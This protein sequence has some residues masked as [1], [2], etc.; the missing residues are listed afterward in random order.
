VHTDELDTIDAIEA[1][2]GSTLSSLVIVSIMAGLMVGSVPEQILQMMAR[3]SKNF[4][5][6]RE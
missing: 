6:V 4:E 5:S 2:K 1:I 3:L